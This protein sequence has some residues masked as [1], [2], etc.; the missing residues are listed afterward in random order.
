MHLVGNLLKV[1]VLYQCVCFLDNFLTS[2]PYRSVK[3]EPR[4]P[5]I[6][7]LSKLLSGIVLCVT[8]LCLVSM[9]PWEKWCASS[10]PGSSA[11]SAQPSLLPPNKVWRRRFRFGGKIQWGRKNLAYSRRQDPQFLYHQL[12]M[13]YKRMSEMAPVI[14]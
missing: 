9:Q 5:E 4:V 13:L 7:S 3:Q 11:V 1:P 10:L 2:L 12:Q 8:E 6:S 14:L